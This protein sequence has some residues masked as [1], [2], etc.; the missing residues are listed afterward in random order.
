MTMQVLFTVTVGRSGSDFVARTLNHFGIGVRAE[1]EPPNL[2][3]ARLGEHRFF[4]R[5]GWL[6]QG[7]RWAQ[8][9]RSLQRRYLFPDEDLGRGPAF[10][11]VEHGEVDKMRRAVE[12]KARRIERF[13]ERGYSHYVE[14]SQFFIRTQADAFFERFPNLGLI[15]LTRDPI[16]AARSLANRDKDILAGGAPP[17][18]RQNIFSVP[19]SA[20]LTRF[21]VFLHRWIETELRFHAYVARTGVSKVFHLRTEE[22]GDRDK[23]AALFDYFGMAHRPIQILPAT[24]T[25]ASQGAPKTVISPRDIAEAAA[26]LDR[27]PENLRRQVP[28]LDAALR[29]RQLSHSAA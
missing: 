12:R 13:A 28:E 5:R 4:S 25:N 2:L 22:L 6:H 17:H 3:L 7:S 23:L 1:H 8:I 24:N 16:M 11:W 14:V 19:E 10:E 18:Y 15:K 29:A 26:L 9:G 21:Q 27:M 20:G